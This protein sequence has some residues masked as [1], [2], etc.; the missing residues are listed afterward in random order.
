MVP[1]GIGLEIVEEQPLGEPVSPAPF[2][3]GLL[4][5]VLRRPHLHGLQFSQSRLP[6]GSVGSGMFLDE[7]LQQIGAFQ[8][9]AAAGGTAGQFP[10]ITQVR[11]I[12]LLRQR[13]TAVVDVIFRELNDRAGLNPSPR[14]DVMGDTR[15]RWA[16]GLP[17]VV[18]IG[19][20]KDDRLL[21]PHIDHEPPDP[22][23]IGLGETQFGIGI[24][25]HGPV[26]MEPGVED[27]H[28]NQAINPFFGH[29][30]F[31]IGLADA[32][33]DAG[34]DLF[35]QTV[36]DPLHRLRQHT[37]PAAA[38]IADNLRPF[39]ADQWSD[40]AEPADFPGHFGSDEV[41][42][43]KYLEIAL[44]MVGEH[45]EKSRVHERFTPDDAEEHIASCLGFVDELVERRDIDDLLFCSNINPAALTAEIAGIDDG[46]VE[47]RGKDFSP[48]QSAFE[49]LDRQSAA[50]AHIPEQLPQQP[51][52]GFEQQPSG[53]PE[54]HIELIE[55]KGRDWEN[56]LRAAGGVAGQ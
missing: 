56:G 37:R 22:L 33:A 16:E 41:T 5:I 18:E 24:G 29:Q 34:E 14:V 21:H 54:V 35:C 1:A 9:N 13:F 42:V 48:F 31:E 17:S 44:R 27:P 53:H 50:H 36:L 51:F 15:G 55:L 8:H 25:P 43:G 11:G 3:N 45:F 23:L 30:I 12:E 46:D 52:V 10:E 39:H 7:L 47:K 28:L 38:F 20:D 2:R 6:G 40:V 32:R 4:G 49:S 26:N 19:I